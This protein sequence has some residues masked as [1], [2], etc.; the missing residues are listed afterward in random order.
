M[1]KSLD[2]FEFP[3]LERL[4]NYCCE[5]SSV[6]FQLDLLILAGDKDNHTSRMCSNFRQI[7]TWTAELAALEYLKKKSTKTYNSFL[8]GSSSFFQEIRTCIKTW[9]C[10]LFQRD[11]TTD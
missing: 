9:M 6:I 4:K 3:A 1:H 2:E 7:Q 8:I 5:H 10:F 11:P